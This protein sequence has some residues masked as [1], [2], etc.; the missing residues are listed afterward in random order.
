MVYD[1]SAESKGISLN[2]CLHSGPCLV[3]TLFDIMLRFRCHLFALVADIEKAFLQIEIAPE[4]RDVLRFLWI[5]DISNEQP[6]IIVQRMTRVTFGVTASPFLL[7]AT[8]QYHIAKYYS[9]EPKIVDNLLRSFYVDDLASGEDSYQKTY[10]LYCTKGQNLFYK[11]GDLPYVSGRQIIQTCV[12]KLV[13]MSARMIQIRAQ[14]KMNP[15][16]PKQHSVHHP[17]LLLK[18]LNK[19][20]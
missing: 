13:K 19:R 11:K 10:E 8:L 17:R 14:T 2:N 16:T 20:C 4:H 3:P 6:N 15:P 5:D 18:E 9:I 7:A 12:A 1:A